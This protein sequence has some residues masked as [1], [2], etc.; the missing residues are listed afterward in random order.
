[1]MYPLKNHRSAVVEIRCDTS[2]VQKVG[3]LEGRE[4]WCSVVSTINMG[5]NVELLADLLHH[6]VVGFCVSLYCS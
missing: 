5:T 6:M 1:M 2:F 3:F 4:S